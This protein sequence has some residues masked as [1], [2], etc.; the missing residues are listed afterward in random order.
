MMPPSASKSE[1]GDAVV[2]FLPMNVDGAAA[3]YAIVPADAL[4]AAPRTV[5]LPDAAALPVGGLTPGRRS[6][7]TLACKRARRC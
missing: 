1:V 5:D 6:S 2:A 4:A 3:E 7:T